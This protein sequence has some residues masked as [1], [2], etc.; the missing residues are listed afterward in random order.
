QDEYRE[1][2]RD[3]KEATREA[4]RATQECRN[5]YL[6]LPDAFRLKIAADLLDDWLK[7]EYPSRG[8]LSAVRKDAGELDAVRRQLRS[9][10]N[11][12]TTWTG[13]QAKLSAGRETLAHLKG[14]LRGNDPAALHQ[15]NASLKSDE[16]SF[17][18]ALKGGKK[19]LQET[20]ADIERIVK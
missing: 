13:L 16:E 9:A 15:R 12:F 5:A 7:S 6:S 1:C 4:E 14:E 11:H 2:S 17:N 19:S 10:Q 8:D 18:N 20:E 3:V